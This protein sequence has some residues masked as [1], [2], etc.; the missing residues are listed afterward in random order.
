MV[1]TPSDKAKICL[2][3]NLT[4][5]RSKAAANAFLVHEP[6]RKDLL[7]ALNR[8]VNKQFMG[9]CRSETF[10]KVETVTSLQHSRTH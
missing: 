3:K 10:Y 7:I 1:R 2:I 8:S 4:L 6:T 9:D 5:N